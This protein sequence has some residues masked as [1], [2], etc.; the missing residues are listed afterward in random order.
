MPIPRRLR[1]LAAPLLAL[2]LLC[3]GSCAFAAASGLPADFHFDHPSFKHELPFATRKVVIQVSVN[4]PAYW[5]L[6]LNNAQ[7]L[8][9][10]FGQQ[11]VRIVVVAFGPGLPMLLKNSAVAARLQSEDSE[12]VEFDACHNTMEAM[13]RK[14]GHMPVLAPQAV[15]VPA[16]VVRIMQLEKAGFA[17]VRP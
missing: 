4:Q 16:G 8:L 6:V 2:C 1:A 5:N 10:S 12:G 11:N 7:N 3:G 13:A 15:V 17:Y 9:D 14:I